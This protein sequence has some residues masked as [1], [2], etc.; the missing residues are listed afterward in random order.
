MLLMSKLNVINSSFT[1]ETTSPDNLVFDRVNN[2]YVAIPLSADDVLLM[3][4]SHHIHLKLR[5]YG[6][7]SF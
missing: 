3:E 1:N 6:F 7:D 4:T 2:F 5:L